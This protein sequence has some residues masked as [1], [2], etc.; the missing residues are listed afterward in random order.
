MNTFEY[1]LRIND[2]DYY[3]F[4]DSSKNEQKR[5]VINNEE[6]VKEKYTLFLN[7]KAYIIYYPIDIEGNELVISIDDNPIVHK[8]NVFLNNVSLIDGTYLDSK[9]KEA[10]LILEKGFK[11]F[12]KENW[13]KIAKEYFWFILSF[14]IISIFL[15][16][17]TFKEFY[18]KILLFL[19]TTPLFL[20]LFIIMEWYHNKNIVKN[21]KNC[22]RPKVFKK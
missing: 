1:N 21:Y 10:N 22:F 14:V 11:I 2:K 9:Y 19:L 4:V 3:I 8:Y 6:I 16:G 17:F 12:A 13:F 7:W 15:D 20:L 5:I 18:I